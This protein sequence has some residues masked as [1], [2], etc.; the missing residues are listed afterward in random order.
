MAKEM[1]R[2]DLL[3]IITEAFDRHARE[4]CIPHEQRIEENEKAHVRIFG[5]GMH[6][7]V[8]EIKQELSEFKK[9]TRAI[10]AQIRDDIVYEQKEFRK[11]MDGIRAKWWI[12]PASIGGS[13]LIA[14]FLNHLMNNLR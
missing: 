3:N 7:D 8:K 10:T 9:E 12:T 6:Q 5:N 4:F 13:V 11:E 2:A 1:T 14:F